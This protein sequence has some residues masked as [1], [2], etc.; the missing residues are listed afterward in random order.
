MQIN[1]KWRS[2]KG[3]RWVSCRVHLITYG[4]VDG[5]GERTDVASAQAVFLPLVAE[6]L[7]LSFLLLIQSITVTYLKKNITVHHDEN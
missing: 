6:D 5:E 1:E 2:I 7:K 4:S 3:C